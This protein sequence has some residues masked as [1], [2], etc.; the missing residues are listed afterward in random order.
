MRDHPPA[1][2]AAQSNLD[3]AKAAFFAANGTVQQIPRGIGK[4]SGLA[5]PGVEPPRYGRTKT[6]TKQTGRGR[7]ISD[8]DK[9]ALAVKLMECKEAGMS[10]YK[11][12]K[13]IGISETLCRRLIADYSLDFPVST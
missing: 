8:E 13:H 7:F 11:A 3:S 1:I 12:G 6:P 10:R 9:A 4:D 2:S 5:P